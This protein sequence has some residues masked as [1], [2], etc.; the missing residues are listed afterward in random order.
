MMQ[1]MRANA[2][3]LSQGC[4]DAMAKLPRPPAPPANWF[5]PGSSRR[6]PPATAVAG[7]T[8]GLWRAAAPACLAGMGGY[9]RSAPNSQTRSSSCCRASRAGA[10]KGA[11]M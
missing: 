5:R 10:Y 2:D 11:G 1:C 4:K 8:K 7:G 9:H 6:A 3:K